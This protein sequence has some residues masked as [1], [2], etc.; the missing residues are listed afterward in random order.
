[1]SLSPLAFDPAAARLVLTANALQ[2]HLACRGQLTAMQRC[3]RRVRVCRDIK[4]VRIVVPAKGFPFVNVQV[5]SIKK[6]SDDLITPLVA[7]AQ[8]HCEEYVPIRLF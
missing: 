1:M 6:R 4:R 7:A 5:G 2:Q 8:L 3:D